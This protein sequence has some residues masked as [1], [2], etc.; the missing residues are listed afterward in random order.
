MMER[1]AQFLGTENVDHVTAEDFSG[2]HIIAPDAKLIGKIHLPEF[3]P[4]VGGGMR[5]RLSIY[6]GKH[7]SLRGGRGSAGSIDS[8][9]ELHQDL[10]ELGVT[11]PYASRAN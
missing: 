7:V 1:Y 11:R 10:L 5:K 2:A 3:T 6:G 4:T 9:S 8:Q